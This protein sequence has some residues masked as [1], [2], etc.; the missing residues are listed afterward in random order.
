M[1]QRNE[2]HNYPSG[3]PSSRNS[4]SSRTQSS[5]VPSSQRV[6]MPNARDELEREREMYSAHDPN[7]SAPSPAQRYAQAQRNQDNRQCYWTQHPGDTGR[8]SERGIN[9]FNNHY[10]ATRRQN[11][12]ISGQIPSRNSNPAQTGEGAL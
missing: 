1:P 7:Q 9:D 5:R 10:D 12:A 4:Y 3:R 11:A 2:P 8:A 6:N